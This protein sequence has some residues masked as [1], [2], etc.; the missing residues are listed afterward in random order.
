MNEKDSPVLGL[1]E[2]PYLN[3]KKAGERF[4]GKLKNP[5]KENILLYWKV[6]TQALGCFT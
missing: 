4:A 1:H 2:G 6:M 5:D 3:R